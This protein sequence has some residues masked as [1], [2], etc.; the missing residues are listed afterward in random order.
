MIFGLDTFELVAALITALAVWLTAR[1]TILCWP[2]S[3][4]ST[5]MYVWV[6]FDA[7][8]YADSGLYVLYGGFAIYGWWLWTRGGREREVL[9][10]SRMHRA[11]LLIALA[12]GAF[13]AIALS[14]TLSKYTDAAVPWADSTLAC[15]SL[16]AQW[17]TARKHLESWIVWIVV[18]VF[19]VALFINRAMIP[20]AVLH[21]AVF[22]VLAVI[23]YLSWRRSM[24]AGERNESS[25]DEPAVESLAT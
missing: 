25:R 5:A 1:Q 13:S 15:F 11:S 14:L 4:I 10:V 23:G 17:M 22:L 8:L 24:S 19:Y 21:G 12:V 6:Y 16:V 9:R 18:D 3:L 7:R 20:T 2:V